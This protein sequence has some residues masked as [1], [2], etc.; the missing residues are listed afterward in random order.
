VQEDFRVWARAE[1]Q[2]KLGQTRLSPA[3]GDVSVF[4][5]IAQHGYGP[6]VRPRIRYHAL[7]ACLVQLGKVASD[8][9]ASVHMPLIGAGQAG[10]DWNVISELIEDE[11]CAR[12]VKATAYA[13][14]TR[15]LEPAQEQPVLGLTHS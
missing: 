10:G 8:L 3:E 5:M 4:S 15:H 12:G 9:G 6:S 11:L 14:P 1:G 2:L 7:R 13:L